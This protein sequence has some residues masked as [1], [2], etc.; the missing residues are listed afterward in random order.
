MCPHRALE[1]RGC[2]ALV[3][4]WAI[5]EFSF[6]DSFELDLS[7]SAD[8]RTCAMGIVAAFCHESAMHCCT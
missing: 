5:T 1:L 3:C 2:L 6:V 4:D 8:A 7:A